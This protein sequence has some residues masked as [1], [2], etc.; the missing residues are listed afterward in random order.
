MAVRSRATTD[1]NLLGQ[2]SSGTTGF[3]KSFT[4]HGKWVP[5]PQ[6]GWTSACWSAE[7]ILFPFYHPKE[8]PMEALPDPPPGD[9]P[10]R[11]YRLPRGNILIYMP[12]EVM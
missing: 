3:T 10:S 1:D 4:V 9:A 7:G 5:L 11:G 6:R 12:I 2:S 8:N